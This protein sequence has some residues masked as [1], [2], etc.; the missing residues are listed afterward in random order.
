MALND[1][2]N[3]DSINIKGTDIENKL[4]LRHIRFVKK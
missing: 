3:I 4:P 2:A 1:I